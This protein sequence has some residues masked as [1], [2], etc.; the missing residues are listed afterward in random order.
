MEEARHAVNQKPTIVMKPNEIRVVHQPADGLGK[1]AAHGDIVEPVAILGGTVKVN[2]H[3][4]V[5]QER[6]EVCEL[7]RREELGSVRC[8]APSSPKLTSLAVPLIGSR[9][10]LVLDNHGHILV[11][12]PKL[13]LE[14]IDKFLRQSGRVDQ[15]AVDVCYG[16]RPSDVD[17]FFG[18]PERVDS[19]VHCWEV[20]RGEEER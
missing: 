5:V 18:G 14:L 16:S 13:L 3:E 8:F 10:N 6:V 17:E 7:G 9:R 12:L 1:L 4:D 19:R 2:V 11:L 20:F 15:V